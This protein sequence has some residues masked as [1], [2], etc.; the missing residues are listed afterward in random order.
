MTYDET[1]KRTIWDKARVI[2]DYDAG[3]WRRDRDGKAIKWVE[4]GN[5]QS[6]YGWEIHHVR[7]ATLGGT[8]TLSNLTPLHWE[9]NARLGGQ[10]GGN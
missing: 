3:E 9:T 2:P 4:F 6:D 5:R 8:D 1:T 10:L 7:A